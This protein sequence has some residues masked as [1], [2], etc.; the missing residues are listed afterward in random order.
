M[1]IAFNKD[2]GVVERQLNYGPKARQ[3]VVGSF[4]I[5]CYFGNLEIANT[6]A[7][8]TF[9]RPDGT[10][11]DVNYVMDFVSRTENIFDKNNVSSID[12]DTYP[13]V[14]GFGYEG[15]VFTPQD[16][17][18]LSMA[19]QYK[20]AVRIYRQND[21]LVQG[22]IVF[23]VENT[24]FNE[25][26][27]ISAT[28]YTELVRRLFGK[29]NSSIVADPYNSESTYENGDVV[30]YDDFL[31]FCTSDISVP[32]V[33]NSSH[34]NKTT[35]I[36]TIDEKITRAQIPEYEGGFDDE[37]LED[38][39]NLVRN[40]AVYNAIQTAAQEVRTDFTSGTL[41]AA[42][43]VN[44]TDSIGGHSLSS[45]FEEDGTTVQE[46]THAVS[47]DS[48]TDAT[49]ATNTFI[50]NTEWRVA[51]WEA[52]GNY[53]NA[54]CPGDVPSNINTPFTMQFKLKA[55]GRWYDLGTHEFVA[56]EIG[57][58]DG[59]NAHHSS[60]TYASGPSGG[61][62]NLY[63]FNL[64][65]YRADPSVEVAIIVQIMHAHFEIYGADRCGA[66]CQWVWPNGDSSYY[67]NATLYYRVIK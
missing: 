33:W 46:A 18:I 8:I 52:A 2:T 54:H 62:C 42:E 31:W 58:S 41:V 34:W 63:S 11:I 13:F 7:T 14:N 9:Q 48:A 15:F 44:V 36:H 60:A 6:T 24:V 37:V 22:E 29:A 26:V 57:H 59:T 51:Q 3:G 45:I 12:A 55:G 28:D 27:S 47:A 5:F 20:A 56:G 30:I 49:N 16:P 40:S 23:N 1:W 4:S 25:Q 32:E 66:S 21:I 67:T 43:A 39:P 38:S 17:A 61:W 19:G 64:Q 10:N 35:I 53:Y 50:T 65:A